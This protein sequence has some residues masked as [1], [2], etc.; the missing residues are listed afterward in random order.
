MPLGDLIAETVGRAIGEFIFHIAAYWTGFVF[1]TLATLGQIKLAPALS[2]GEKNIGK[3]KWYRLDWSIWLR[4][5][6]SQKELKA[7][8]VSLVGIL[9]WVAVGFGIYLALQTEGAIQAR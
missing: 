9:V 6:G 3:K 1:L 8:F 2:Y 7:E 4:G 5:T